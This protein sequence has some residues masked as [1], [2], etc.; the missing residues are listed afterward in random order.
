MQ[1]LGTGLFAKLGYLIRFPKHLARLFRDG[2]VSERVQFFGM[3]MFCIQADIIFSSDLL[4]SPFDESVKAYDSLIAP[5]MVL[6]GIIGFWACFRTSQKTPE[7]NG[8]VSRFVCLGALVGFYL[9]LALFVILNVLNQ[10]F[11]R[12][13]PVPVITSAIQS[14]ST[15]ALDLAILLG[16]EIAGFWL[17]NR[18]IAESYPVVLSAKRDNDTPSKPSVAAVPQL[19]PV[20]TQE[21]KRLLKEAVRQTLSTLR[22]EHPEEHF[23]AFALYDADGDCV[24]PS[25]NSEENYQSVIG[26]KKCTDTDERFQYRWSTAEWGYEGVEYG[27][28][29]Q[30]RNLLSLAHYDDWTEF[31]AASFGTSILALQELAEEGF[32][33]TGK[34]RMTVF[35]SLSDSGY[36]GWLELESARRINPP[37]IFVAFERE[38]RIA[39]ADHWGVKDGNPDGGELATVFLRMFGSMP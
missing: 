21:V 39:A 15:N 26:R 35:F 1:N 7:R 37:E 31:Q 6:I 17:L 5:S 16:Y 11:E 29:D 2:T 30:V 14:T 22:S 8:F 27:P 24:C 4:E 9:Y 19:R 3:V 28:F 36:A 32:F 23:Y 20:D 12:F 18:L 34:S 33:G 13:I 25:T 38:W 10:I